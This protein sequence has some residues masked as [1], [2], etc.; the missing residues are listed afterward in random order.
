MMPQLGETVTEGTIT[1]WMK[2]VGD[3]VERDEPLFEVSTDKVDSEVPSPAAGVLTEI[4]VP[5]GETVEVGVRLAVIGDGD[6]ALPVPTP[7]PA[8]TTAADSRVPPRRTPSPRRACATPT[9]SRTSPTG[10]AGARTGRGEQRRQRRAA[11][12]LADRAPDPGRERH[13]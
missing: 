6:R 12:P 13:R 5:E 4:L 2:G 3:Q 11:A 9:T 1:R 10:G 8:T 7:Q